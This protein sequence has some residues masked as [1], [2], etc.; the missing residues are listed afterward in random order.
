M[1]ISERSFGGHKI[2]LKDVKGQLLEAKVDL[3]CKD[4]TENKKRYTQCRII[5]KWSDN[6]IECI[7]GNFFS[8]F[9]RIRE[10]LER[11]DIYPI[12]YAANRNIVVTGMAIEMSLGLKI[13]KDVKLGI[14][15]ARNQLVD[16]FKTDQDVEPVTVKEQKKFQREWVQSLK[17]YS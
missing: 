8:A 12:C 15:P 7:E 9:N 14:F 4:W 1:N 17:K 3:Y 13:Y 5:L 6:Q 2:Y 11:L 10:Q 16:I